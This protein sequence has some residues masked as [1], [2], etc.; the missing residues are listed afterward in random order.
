M[1]W[2]WVIHNGFAIFIVG[3]LIKAAVGAAVLPGAWAAVRKFERT[4]DKE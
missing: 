2:G 4:D 1:D 3:G